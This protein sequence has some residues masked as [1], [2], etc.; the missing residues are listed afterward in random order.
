[1]ECRVQDLQAKYLIP[2]VIKYGVRASGMNIWQASYPIQ[3]H[4]ILNVILPS[5]HL[6]VYICYDYRDKNNFFPTYPYRVF[7][8]M[9]IQC[10]SFCILTTFNII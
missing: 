10:I 9:E 6:I 3:A 7:F 5:P 2:A 8:L 1:M 4:T